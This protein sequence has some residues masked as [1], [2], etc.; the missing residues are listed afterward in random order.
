MAGNRSLLHMVYFLFLVLLNTV[1]SWYKFDIIMHHC[2]A[3]FSC[4][5]PVFQCSAIVPII[6]MLHT[7]SEYIRKRSERRV[8]NVPRASLCPRWRLLWDRWLR[9]GNDA[10]GAVTVEAMGL[11]CSC[12]CCCRAAAAAAL[13]VVVRANYYWK[14]F[15][16]CWHYYWNVDRLQ[17][18]VVSTLH[19][20]VDIISSSQNRRS[21]WTISE[22]TPLA[23]P[24]PCTRYTRR[25]P[26]VRQ[27][28]HDGLSLL[29]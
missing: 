27:N 7:H 17:R 23:E 20:C 9:D 2:I 16:D 22:S 18:V 29:L 10:V 6:E 14:H 21:K 26:C 3:Q 13:F 15:D 11:L 19:R 28:G 5:C 24:S 8:V 1:L 12:N 4:I 25:N